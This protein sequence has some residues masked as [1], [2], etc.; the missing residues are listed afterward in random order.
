MHQPSS[1]NP[2]RLGLT[3]LQIASVFSISLPVA[4]R[5]VKQKKGSLRMTLTNLPGI[6]HEGAGPR[7]VWGFGDPVV[8]GE[9]QESLTRADDGP[10][11]T[12][13]PRQLRCNPFIVTH[14]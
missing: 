10:I 7:F 8:H 3:L 11:L 5:R 12:Q 13:V 4:R 14:Q 9:R 1:R 2:I 6:W